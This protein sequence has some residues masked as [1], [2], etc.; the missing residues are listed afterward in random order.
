MADSRASMKLA[1][2]G[3]NIY[4][5]WSPCGHYVAVGN[6]SDTVAVYDIRTE[7]QVAKKH[8]EYEVNEF[9]WTDESRYLLL[10]TGGGNAGAVDIVSF[11]SECSEEKK[12]DSLSVVDSISAHFS[13]CVQLKLDPTNRRMA[14]GSLDRTVSLWSVEDMICHHTFSFE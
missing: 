5:C 12:D 13:Y 1:S 8:F 9:A 2:M 7:K 14:V 3:G 10:A 11:S 4:S 6:K